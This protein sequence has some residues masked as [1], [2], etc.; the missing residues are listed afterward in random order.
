VAAKPRRPRSGLPAQPRTANEL[1]ADAIIRHQVGLLR[2]A[3]SLDRRT[4]ELLDATEVD[5]RRAIRRRL[6]LSKGLDRPSDLARL[7]ALLADVRRIRSRAWK[8]VEDLWVEE[9]RGLA[10]T[11]ATTVDEIL[12]AAA[13]VQLGT[14]VPP[15]PALRALVTSRPFEGRILRDWARTVRRN[16]LERVERAI[17]VGLVQGE[18]G[19]EIARRVVG[20]VS[21]GG[22]G[23]ATAIARNEAVAVVRTAVVAI[24][25][26][27]RGALYARNADLL[28]AEVFLATLDSRTTPECRA[29]DGKRFRVGEGPIPPL[30]WQCRSTR[31]PLLDDDVIG[32]RPFKAS[33]ERGLLREF[34]AREGF[35]AP[36]KRDGLPHG[37]KGDFDAFAR[38]RV[39]DLTG[40]VPAKTTYQEWLGRQSAEFQNDVLGPTRGK[41]FRRGGLA[42]DRFVDRHGRELTLAELAIAHRRAFVEAGLDPASFAR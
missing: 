18:S 20:A 23:G 24:A 10:V 41:L 17:K 16:D 37:T 4:R 9:G 15:A 38:R 25:S 1:L 26:A 42:L 13:P 36:A 12:R 27:A 19:Q 8:S 22:R 34:A 40:R 3:G 32:D 14:S 28:E 31:M 7:E 11:E 6:R 33:T 29:N 21:T 39:R 5:L 35:G 30:H 2:Y